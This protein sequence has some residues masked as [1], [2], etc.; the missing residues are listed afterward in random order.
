M[1]IRITKVEQFSSCDKKI[2]TYYHIERKY[3]FFWTQLLH[4]CMTTLDEAE[5]WAENYMYMNGK[6]EQSSVV[7]EYNVL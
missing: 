1:K 7:K 2:E 5:K 6:A 3:L 4:P